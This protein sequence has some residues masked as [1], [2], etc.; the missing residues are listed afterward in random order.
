MNLL[1]IDVSEEDVA[2]SSEN[3]PGKKVQSDYYDEPD[4]DEDVMNNDENDDKDQW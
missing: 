1:L 3:C 4:A 2:T